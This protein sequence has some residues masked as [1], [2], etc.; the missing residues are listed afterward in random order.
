[1]T[2]FDYGIAIGNLVPVL[3]DTDI[4][5]LPSFHYSCKSIDFILVIR[6]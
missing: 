6:F 1:M 4:L 2:I 5:R 3:L